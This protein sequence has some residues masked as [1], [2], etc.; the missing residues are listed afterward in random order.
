M[1]NAESKLGL[2]EEAAGRSELGF[3]P[4]TVVDGHRQSLRTVVRD[5]TRVRAE[6]L[7]LGSLTG[8]STVLTLGQNL[9][10]P[11]A[12]IAD[13]RSVEVHETVG[14]PLAVRAKPIDKKNEASGKVLYFFGAAEAAAALDGRRVMLAPPGGEATVTTAEVE[15]NTPPVPHLKDAHEVT[16]NVDVA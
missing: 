13:I 11:G 6:S 14:P 1:R 2:V 8:A 16:L 9:A 5:V 7:H 15:Q 10:L 3:A 4:S 12:A